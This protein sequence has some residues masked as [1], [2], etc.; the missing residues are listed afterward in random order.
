MTDLTDDTDTA[1]GTCNLREAIQSA[2]TN[3]NV[4]ACIRTG[5]GNDTI[6]FGRTG[7]IN[8]IQALPVITQGVRII[9]PGADLLTVDANGFAR[10][11]HIQPAAN[12]AWYLAGMTLTDGDAGSFFG[13]NGGGLY[14][15]NVGVGGTLTLEDMVLTGNNAYEGG[16][17]FAEEGTVIVRRSTISDNTAV[18][19]GGG[20]F[21][22]E[23]AGEFDLENST[24]SG[25]SAA[26]G[27]GFFNG[28]NTTVLR[29]TISGNMAEGNGGGIAHFDGDGGNTLTIKHSTITNNSA[30]TDLSNGDG[31][32]LYFNNAQNLTTKNTIIAGNFDLD[33]TPND[34]PDVNIPS[35]IPVTS[36]GYSLI[37][38]NAGGTSAYPSGNPNANDDYVGTAAAPIVANLGTLQDNSGPTFTHHPTGMAFE[39]VDQGSCGGEGYDQRGAAGNIDIPFRPRDLA[40]PNA[41]DGCDIGAV[42]NAGNIVPPTYDIKV[43]LDGP[44][45]NVLMNTDLNAAGQLPSD[46]P[47]NTAP[48]NYGGSENLTAIP[49]D[50][51]DWVLVRFNR[52]G[53][54]DDSFASS[55]PRAVYVE[56]NGDLVV[57]DAGFSP[58][59]PDP[60]YHYITIGHRNHLSVMT[61]KPVQLVWGETAS[62]D[63]RT[64][65]GASYT[66]GGQAVRDRG[67]GFF[68]MW[69]G[70]GNAN[71]S[72]T[73]FD[74]LNVW[75]PVNGG[76]VGYEAGDF[77]MSGNPTAFDFLN[78]WLPANGQATQVPN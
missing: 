44:Y 11:M 55:R 45:T 36:Q 39:I 77:D 61:A 53:P 58:Y 68:T 21:A 27:G 48:W 9:G 1:N 78:V 56:N 24:V 60:G 7:I 50:M 54:L 17:L 62:Y 57:P 69:G 6:Y 65:L 23:S 2:E 26:L 52:G 32:G 64:S 38:N 30:A 31:G 4:D 33:P 41:D 28:V 3:T 72:V 42:E 25:N 51:V 22:E 46:Q 5:G 49:N 20:I 10:V 74:F 16:G 8:L 70:D 73:A 71:N 75:L 35:I 76:P 59:R 63:F 40:T 47:Y 67:D 34:R 12:G 43:L 66:S 18:N 37:G 15:D 14:F 29:S 13:R 19:A